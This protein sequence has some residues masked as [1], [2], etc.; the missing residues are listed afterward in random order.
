MKFNCYGKV[1]S[2]VRQLADPSFG[3]VDESG[4]T[5]YNDSGEQIPAWAS[6]NE[7]VDENG[8]DKSYVGTHGYWD[9]II[10]P[11]GTILARYG[12][13]IGRLTTDKGTP[14][15]LLGLPYIKATCEYHEYIVCGDVKVKC[16]VKRGSVYKM[17]NSEGGAIQYYH[18]QSIKKELQDNKLKEVFGWIEEKKSV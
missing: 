18:S 12:S 7:F 1:I 10:L 11:K 4:K 17:F 15:E 5:L 9:E 14:Y 13:E 8:F 3:K 16:Q 2:G 6:P